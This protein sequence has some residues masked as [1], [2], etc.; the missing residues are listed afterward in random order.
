MFGW[1]DSVVVINCLSRQLKRKS[2][3]YRKRTGVGIIV[4][5]H[6]FNRE[7]Q[8]HILADWRNN[9]FIPICNHLVKISRHVI[10]QHVVQDNLRRYRK[11][12]AGMSYN[13]LFAILVNG[14]SVVIERHLRLW[15]FHN[16]SA[17][18]AVFNV[19]AGEFPGKNSGEKICLWIC[20]VKCNQLVGNF[21]R[22][23]FRE[24]YINLSIWK[25]LDGICGAKGVAGIY[26]AG[27]QVG[28]I[29]ILCDVKL[30]VDI[31]RKLS[32]E[33]VYLKSHRGE[34][35]THICSIIYIEFNSDGVDVVARKVGAELGRRHQLSNEFGA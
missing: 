3:D 30:T 21:A 14:G 33:F 32:V 24:F 4:F 26:F 1:C 29:I 6:F 2:V 19:Y 17:A 11:I 8:F 16:T 34:R 35:V 7:L 13:F 15:D 12:A 31:G 27:N 18:I 25:I 9:Y 10:L 28:R 22:S 20:F 23:G 5:Y